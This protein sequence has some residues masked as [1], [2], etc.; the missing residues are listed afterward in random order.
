MQISSSA[1]TPT[2]KSLQYQISAWLISGIL[3][4]DGFLLDFTNISADCFVLEL[5]TKGR[6]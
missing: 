3:R 1:D 6:F 5:S 2:K 4:Y